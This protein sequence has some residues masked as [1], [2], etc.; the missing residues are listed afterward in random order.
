MINAIAIDDEPKAISIIESHISK[1]EDVTLLHK[2]YDPK[3]ALAF[4]R[5]N[6]VDLIFLDINMPHL[7]GLELME[8]LRT[9]PLLVFT[10]AYAE[11]ALESYEYNAIDYLLKPFEF[12]RFK[13]AIDKA[14]E[15]LKNNEQQ[16]TFFFIRDGFSTIKIRFNDILL[17]KGSGN[18]LDI[19]TLEK[20]YSPRMTFNDILDKIPSSVFIRV[21]QSYLVN[22]NHIDK[23]ESNYIFLKEHKAPISGKYREQVQKRLGLFK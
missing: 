10:T 20:T 21:H 3:K 6:P 23:I 14:R 12:G 17:I 7:S 19:V 8:K 9:K 4:L 22:L 2:F 15:R 18:Y 1:I 5:E 11:F 16:N 13:I